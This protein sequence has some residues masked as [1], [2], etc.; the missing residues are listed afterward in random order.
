MGRNAS[1]IY[2]D[3]TGSSATSSSSTSSSSTS[4][5]STSSSSTSSS[6]TSSSSTSSS[7]TSS[8]STSSSATSSSST[9]GSSTSSS[10]TS[11]S[12]DDSMLRTTATSKP[13]Y[14]IRCTLQIYYRL[15]A[16][17]VALYNNYEKYV[18]FKVVQITSQITSTTS[19]KVGSA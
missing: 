5:S 6:S 14:N 12:S 3:L 8:S 9:S 2:Q 1:I 13:V 11:S 16:I 19:Y 4:S 18:T 10:S 17:L 7:S 15:V